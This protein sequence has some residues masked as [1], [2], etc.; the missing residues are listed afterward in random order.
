MRPIL[1]TEPWIGEAENQ[2]IIRFSVVKATEIIAFTGHD[3]AADKLVIAIVS[4][5]HHTVWCIL[6]TGKSTV[7]LRDQVGRN[8]LCPAA[9]HIFMLVIVA[10]IL[11]RFCPLGGSANGQCK[12]CTA[13]FE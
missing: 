6:H 9:V 2:E 10:G 12:K 5:N 11:F 1:A 13:R 4:F 8:G 7:L 3:D